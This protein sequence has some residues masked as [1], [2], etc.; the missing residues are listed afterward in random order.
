LHILNFFE[1]A[2]N[3]VFPFYALLEFTAISLPATFAATI[4]LS[5]TFAATISLPATFA[6]TISLPA[7]FAAIILLPAT[8][9]ATISLPATF[10]AIILLPATFA[11]TIFYQASGRP[12]LLPELHK[13]SEELL[14]MFPQ[15]LLLVK[16]FYNLFI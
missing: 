3:V 7:T 12:S 15:S 4:S 16:I 6:A 14:N 11:T 13:A 5:A 9:A 10:A 2:T 8:F 1:T